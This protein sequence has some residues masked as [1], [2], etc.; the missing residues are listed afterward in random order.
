MKS[1]ST[2]LLITALLA[3]VF[4]TSCQNGRNTKATATS[5]FILWEDSAKQLSLRIENYYNNDENDSVYQLSPIAMELCREHGLWRYYYYTWN[6]MAMTYIWDNQPDLAIKEARL[7]QEDALKRNNNYGLVKAYTILGEAYG[8]QD[9]YTE[10]ASAYH[11]ALVIHKD[12]AE[13]GSKS[14]IYGKY[15]LTLMEQGKFKEMDSVL[16]KWKVEVEQHPLVENHNKSVIAHCHYEYL[17]WL[18]KLLMHNKRYREAEATVDSATYYLE[19]SGRTLINM[20]RHENLR[21]ELAKCKGDYNEALESCNRKMALTPSKSSSNYL[22]ALANRSIV[23]ELQGRYKEALSDYREYNA[24][25]DS[26]RQEETQEQLNELN[27]RFELNELKAEKEREQMEAR[28]RQLILYIIIASLLVIGLIVYIL[29]HR[30]AERRMAVL[31]AQK[32]RMESELRIAHDIQMKMVPNEFPHVEHLNMYA[33]MTPAK[34]VGG[35]LY[36]YLLSDDKLY[37]CLGDVSGKG[38]PAALFMT[39]AVKLFR[40]IA[41]Q[42]L[43]PAKMATRIN[44]ELTENNEQGM[45]VTM[46]IG[47]LNLKTYHLD[48]CNCGHNPPAIGASG[49]KFDFLRMESNF[50][51]GVLPGAEFKGEE[52]ESIHGQTLLLYSDGLNEADNQQLE[53]FGD[54]RLLDILRRTHFGTAREV[55]ETLKK[56]V[57][58]HRNGAE[59]ND[60]LS[61]FCL[62]VE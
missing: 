34:E 14:S 12:T 40:A 31:S 33:S 61:M 20:S 47:C 32:E 18:A 39:Q 59:P 10:M 23:Y 28:H 35:D 1:K 38:V 13:F 7:M 56:E 15:C 3:S 42:K 19:I 41:K 6:M 50:P 46:F 60:D 62:M 2:I 52:I 16:T 30:R 36:D 27:K 21:L 57:E 54:N 49:S 53:Q 8:A 58:A 11:N 26:V 9:N 43:S 44:D 22:S 5:D 55:I 45:F 37:F 51:L 48:F 25:K 4:A 17:Y 24:L 29:L